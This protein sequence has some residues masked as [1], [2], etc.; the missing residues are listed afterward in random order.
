MFDILLVN[1]YIVWMKT[2]ERWPLYGWLT[3]TT[4]DQYMQRN[5]RRTCANVAKIAIYHQAN[6][7]SA[8][9]SKGKPE[10]RRL[11]KRTKAVFQVLIQFTSACLADVVSFSVT[12]FQHSSNR[13]FTRRFLI[14]LH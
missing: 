5:A 12:E 4:N 14:V 8:R 6:R 1:K 10:H 2:Q 11:I 3:R 13:N 7:Y 9:K